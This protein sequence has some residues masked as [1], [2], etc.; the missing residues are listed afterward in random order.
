LVVKF[1]VP[2]GSLE[3]GTHDILARAMLRLRGAERTYRPV[4]DDPEIEVKVLRP[5]EIPVLVAGGAFDIG[6]TGRDWVRETGADVLQLLDLEYGYVR[7]VVAVP[8]NLHHRSLDEIV[9]EYAG[10]G[11]VLRIATEYLNTAAAYVKSTPAYRRHFGESEP[12]IVTP[13]WSRGEN[14]RGVLSKS[15]MD[16][17]GYASEENILPPGM[18]EDKDAC[19]REFKG[20]A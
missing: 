3:E 20:D 14:D 11:K 19:I 17:G 6:I 1:A 16:M 15:V 2:K 12:M 5:Q 8:E 13:W 18:V 9:E 7:L 4:V 10:A